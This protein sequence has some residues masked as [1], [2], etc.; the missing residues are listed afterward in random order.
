MTQSE[1]L[2]K[3]ELDDRMLNLDESLHQ[4]CSNRIFGRASRVFVARFDFV[5]SFH[6]TKHSIP[7]IY[8]PQTWQNRIKSVLQDEKPD[9]ANVQARLPG[10]ITSPRFPL[11]YAS[12]LKQELGVYQSAHPNSCRVLCVVILKQYLPITDLVGDRF[13]LAFWECFMCTLI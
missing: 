9:N 3:D 5:H 10:V 11:S 12:D 2:V 13:W 7:R 8:C 6:A 1:P 4:C